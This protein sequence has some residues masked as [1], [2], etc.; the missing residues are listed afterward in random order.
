M[1]LV[2][3]TSETLGKWWDST[4]ST[5]HGLLYVTLTICMQGKGY[6]PSS[7]FQAKDTKRLGK[8]SQVYIV[9]VRI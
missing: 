8:H 3:I 4:P 9:N 2:T 1:K 6:F 5:L 7:F